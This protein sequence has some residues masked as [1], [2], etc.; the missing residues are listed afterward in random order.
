MATQKIAITVPPLFL[1]RLDD[2]AKKMGR[3]RSRFIV[4]EIDNSLRKLEDQE[5]T[6]L[7]NEAYGEPETTAQDSQ[8][9]EEMF[10]IS[11]IHE[12]EDKW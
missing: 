4:E 9:T 12:M 1:K 6:Q 5:I 7:Y 3:S 10:N 8:L 11:A 2:W